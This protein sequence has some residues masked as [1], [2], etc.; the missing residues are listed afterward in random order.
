LSHDIRFAM[1]VLVLLS[2]Y[3]ISFHFCC[4]YLFIWKTIVLPTT[5]LI[6]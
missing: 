4:L 3:F 2:I 6:L 5:I 1:S